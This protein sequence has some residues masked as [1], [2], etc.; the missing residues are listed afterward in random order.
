MKVKIIPELADKQEIILIDADEFLREQAER[1]HQAAESSVYGLFSE[2]EK[3]KAEA[4]LERL[5]KEGLET[6]E[7]FRKE[8]DKIYSEVFGRKKL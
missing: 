4:E 6:S 1:L 8:V 2:E 7:K 5:R 3:L